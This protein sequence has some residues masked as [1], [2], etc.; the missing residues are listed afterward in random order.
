MYAS[1]SLLLLQQQNS[2]S[3]W[4]KSWGK[5][6]LMIIVY[7]SCCIRCKN[8]C[9]SLRWSYT[10]LKSELPCCIWKILGCTEF[11][12]HFQKFRTEFKILL[13]VFKIFRGLAPSYLSS[14][15][16]SKPV[17]KYNE[18]LA[19]GRRSLIWGGGAKK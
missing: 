16:T 1:L 15:I 2:F 18:V 12:W 3:C 13:I 6:A 8:K 17:S 9:S 11:V 19:Q 14:L 10:Y 7:L 5:Y 4:L